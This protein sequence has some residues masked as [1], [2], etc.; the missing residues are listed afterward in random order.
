MTDATDIRLSILL[1]S[2][3]R[4]VLDSL[5]LTLRK[6]SGLQVNHKL[7]VNGHVDPLHDLTEMPDVLVLHLG[8]SWQAELQSLAARPTDQ[9]PPLVV[10][11]STNDTS[12]LRLAMHAGARDFL[13]LPLIEAD[14][15]AVL[16]RIARDRRPGSLN[17]CNLT[18]FVNAKG[19]CG[20]TFLACNI[21]HMIAARMHKR[22]TLVDFDLQFGAV[23]LYFDKFPTRG[24]LQAIENAEELD[25]VALNAY[26]T[27]DES[28]L[29]ILGQSSNDSLT[30]DAIPSQSLHRML[31]LLRAANEHVV[32]DLARHMDSTACAVLERS[33]R[34][35]VVVQQSVTVLR[36]A[37]RLLTFLRR[38][39]SLTPERLLLVVNRYDKH[40]DITPDDICNT[41]SCA[42]PLLVPNDYRS[43]SQSIGSGR[44]LLT[45]APSA[46]ATRALIELTE[47]ICGQS[48]PEVRGLFARAFSRPGKPRTN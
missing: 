16:Q 9:R 47:R 25:N 32:V 20:G 31:K 46:P 17:H 5:R 27:Q 12:A 39:L 42:A 36:D 21:A 37:G 33:D 22:A 48:A 41:L 23:P 13:P 29:S 14:F 3:R 19:G 15:V 4:E 43:V 35:V 24:L 6:Y 1:V 28:G 40:S 10:I 18:A 7:V 2:R 8:E 30:L 11:G 45:S 26:L 34:V 38:E 44:P